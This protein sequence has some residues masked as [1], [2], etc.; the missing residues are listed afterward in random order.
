MCGISA[1][2]GDAD[3]EIKDILASA[4]NNKHRGDDGVGIIFKDKN[5]KLTVCK[6][7]LHL[8]E[9]FDAKL[10]ENRAL[11]R[12]K[13]G[14]IGMMCKDDELYGK[15]QTEHEKEMNKLLTTK[16]NLIVVHHRKA[17]CG[18]NKIENLHPFEYDGKY[19]VHNGTAEGYQS[20]KNWL[21]INNGIKFKSDT[22]TEVLA[23]VYNLL[24]ENF[25]GKPKEVFKRMSS[26]FP[27]GF[28]VIL[29]ITDS[30]ITIIK[31]EERELWAYVYGKNQERVYLISE[32]SPGRDKFNKLW[33]VAPGIYDVTGMVVTDYTK[34]GKDALKCWNDTFNISHP[35]TGKC[36]CCKSENK[37]IASAYYITE[38]P[39]KESK[40]DRCYECLVRSDLCAVDEDEE[41]LSLSERETFASFIEV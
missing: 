19:Y 30:N 33:R 32:P 3:R 24:K 4:V 34:E 17:T 8:D 11:R 38:G 15:L 16:S 37:V 1:Y 2:I 35:K 7:L 28:G 31:D 22:D 10:E 18:D 5:K 41:E 25:K 21:E 23:V 29:E 12:K 26:M 39:L 36:D 6:N 20:I 27:K 13:I 14:S 40:E 9:M